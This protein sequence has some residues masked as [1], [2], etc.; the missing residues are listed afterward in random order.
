MFAI[1]ANLS[2][3]G[4]LKVKIFPFTKQSLVRFLKVLKNETIW[5]IWHHFVIRTV[6]SCLMGWYILLKISSNSRNRAFSFDRWI[7]RCWCCSPF[8]R[9]REIGSKE[10]AAFNYSSRWYNFIEFGRDITIEEEE[11]DNFLT[12]QTTF[13]IF[14]L[15]SRPTYQIRE[16]TTIF[17]CFNGIWQ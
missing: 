7:V 13:K 10:A 11:P 12:T 5:A 9:A 14:L 17:D 2:F 3:M 8:W 16:G 1:S 6:H 4:T 15:S